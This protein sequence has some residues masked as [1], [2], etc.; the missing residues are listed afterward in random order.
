MKKPQPNRY[1]RLV[2]RGEKPIEIIADSKLDAQC[3]AMDA[4]RHLKN[5]RVLEFREVEPTH[6]V[7]N[8]IR[9]ERQFNNIFA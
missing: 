6:N 5:Y 2:L 8:Q 7:L 9:F 4:K 3:Q 1:F